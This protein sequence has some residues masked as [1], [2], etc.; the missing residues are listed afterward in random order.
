MLGSYIS[1]SRAISTNHH[2]DKWTRHEY[3]NV[4]LASLSIPANGHKYTKPEALAVVLA[5]DS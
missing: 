4:L 1:L 5:Y 3:N 2:R